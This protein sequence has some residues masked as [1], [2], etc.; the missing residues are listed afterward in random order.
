M[1]SLEPRS[2]LSPSPGLLNTIGPEWCEKQSII[3]CI[4]QN[5]SMSTAVINRLTAVRSLSSSFQAISP[6]SRKGISIFRKLIGV[7]RKILRLNTPPGYQNLLRGTSSF[8]V[9]PQTKQTALF[10][11]NGNDTVNHVK[12]PLSRTQ[13]PC[14]Q[15][16]Q[17][18]FQVFENCMVFCHLSLSYVTYNASF[19]FS[20]MWRIPLSYASGILSIEI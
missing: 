2:T 13:C 19:H 16:F 5:Q 6:T 11:A 17:I 12:I 8:V 1:P 20:S 9:R 10:S 18:I 14:F 15:M 3:K 4:C 7:R